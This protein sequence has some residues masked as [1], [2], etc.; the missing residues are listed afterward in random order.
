MVTVALS[1]VLLISVN[2]FARTNIVNATIDSI[3]PIYMNYS[4]EK[5]YQALS[6]NRTKNGKKLLER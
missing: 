5:N 6:S 2:A 4:V 3:K 1:T